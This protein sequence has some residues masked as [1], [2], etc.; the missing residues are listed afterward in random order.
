MARKRS[1][2]MFQI[3]TVRDAIRV[4]GGPEYLAERLNRRPSAIG[5]WVTYG[6]VSGG[7]RIPVLLSLEALGYKRQNINPQIFDYET[8]DKAIIAKLRPRRRAL[9]KAA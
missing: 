8:W 1:K 6:H 7:F 5:M 4:L 3:D 2:S 9:G